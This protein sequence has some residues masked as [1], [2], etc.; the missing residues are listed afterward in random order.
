MDY[1]KTLLTKILKDIVYS[2][3]MNELREN[4][5]I[6]NEFV[7]KYQI[8]SDSEEFKKL[9]NAIVLMKIK[10]KRDKDF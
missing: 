4:V 5:R 7:H 3:N 8:T 1:K 10:L 6:A 9:D 2:S